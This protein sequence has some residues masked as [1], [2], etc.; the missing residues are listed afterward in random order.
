MVM[1]ASRDRGWGGDIRRARIFERLAERQRRPDRRRLADVPARDPGPAL[2]GL[3]ARAATTTAS[4]R[5]RDRAA[6][7]GR[8]DRRP[9]GPRRG[10]DLRRL[11]RPGAGTRS[12]SES[13]TGGRPCAPAARQRGGIPLA[14]R[15]DCVVRRARRA[16]P[17]ADHR[18]RQ[19]DRREPRPAGPVAG[20]ADRRLRVGGRARTRDR[21]PPRGRPA[22][23]GRGPRDAPAAVVDRDR[24]R[25]RGIHRWPPGGR[26]E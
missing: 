10:R 22:G 1:R 3:A 17:V 16:R 2:A 26:G 5:L 14:R 24:A 23:Q 25:R 7:V 12:R 15:A 8:A 21:D 4:R 13:G 18:R 11:R 20:G 9:V 6:E 19:R